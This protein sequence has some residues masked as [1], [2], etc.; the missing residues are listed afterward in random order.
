MNMRPRITNLYVA[1][2]LATIGGLIQGFDVAS[3]SAV[4]GTPQVCSRPV[5]SASDQLRRRIRGPDD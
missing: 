5:A 2:S 3:M 1:S 4:L